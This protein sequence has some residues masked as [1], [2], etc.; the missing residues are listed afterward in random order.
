MVLI[1][2]GNLRQGIRLYENVIEVFLENKS[3]YRYAAGN[4]LMGMVYSKFTQAKGERKDFSFI[5]KNF[6]F[7]M[8]TLPFAHKKAEEHLNI[9]IKTAGEIGAKSVLGQSY[10]ELGKLYQVKGRT[11]KARKCIANAIEV[12]EHCEAETFL[13]QAQAALASLN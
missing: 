12:F 5:A 10:L 3:L 11:E 13:N 9:A 1:A 6:G 8:K 2:Q 4:Q 7:L